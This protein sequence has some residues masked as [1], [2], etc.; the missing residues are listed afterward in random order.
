MR[1]WEG[2]LK[3]LKLIDKKNRLPQAV[4]VC[5]LLFSINTPRAF[6]QSDEAGQ[7]AATEG[8]YQN[9]APP[10][11]DVSQLTPIDWPNAPAPA[12]AGRSGWRSLIVGLLALLLSAAAIYGI[13][14]FIKKVTRRAEV[15]D[16]YLKLLASASLGSGAYAHVLSL[17]TKAWLV[18]ASDGGVSL[19]SEVEDQDVLN[20]MILDDSKKSAGR[21]PGGIL[22]FKALLGRFGMQ[23]KSGLP[24]PENIRRHRNRVKGV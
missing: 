5:V 9:E 1:T 12:A 15:Q 7:P 20:A 19:I 18:G 8:E 11:A 6:A 3:L 24:G 23:V 2:R 4:C 14:F 22:D 13:V 16:P 10:Q 21:G 17:G